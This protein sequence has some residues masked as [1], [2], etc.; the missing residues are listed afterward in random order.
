MSNSSR[1]PESLK[2]TSVGNVKESGH[3]HW[4]SPSNIALVKYWGKKHEQIPCNPSISFTLKNAHTNTSLEWERKVTTPSGNVDFTFY[5]HGQ[6]KESFRKRI[7]KYL[8]RLADEIPILK[9]YRLTISSENTFPHSSGIASSA[10]AMNALAA[11]L[12]DMESQI[13][14]RASSDA[15]GLPDFNQRISRLSRLGSGSACRS[16]YPKAALWGKCSFPGSSDEYAVG[17]E[18]ILH[19]AFHDYKD[20]ILLIDQSEKKVSSSAGHQLM[21][22]NPY[23]EVRY[24]EARKNTEN[25]LS[26]LISGNLDDFT[27]L[28]EAEAMTLHALMMASS[29]G[30]IL[31]LPNT[32]YIIDRIREFRKDTGIPLCFTLDAGPNVHLLYPDQYKEPVK[33]F[34]QTDLTTFC[35]DGQWIDDEMGNGNQKIK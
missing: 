12:I 30:Y 11:A 18:S 3:C 28:V 25:L 2:N 10:S 35:S 21:N 26:I 6:E 9:N 13:S 23:A 32:L 16:N 4:Q 27:S 29:P 22:G 1:F 7:Q 24:H 20:A 8:N 14:G 5:F 33:D 19:P 17:L 31:M 34:I 15:E